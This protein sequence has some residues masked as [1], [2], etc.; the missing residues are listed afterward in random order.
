MAGHGAKVTLN[1]MRYVSH[2]I[3][4]IMKYSSG[5][6]SVWS[7]PEYCGVG[8]EHVA[9]NNYRCFVFFEE[10]RETWQKLNKSNHASRCRD[11]SL[12][13]SLT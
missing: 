12:Q 10:S 2:M 6:L 9:L 1:K 5:P 4:F 13:G 8:G 11:S 7:G 3:N